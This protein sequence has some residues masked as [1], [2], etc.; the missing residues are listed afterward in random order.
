MSCFCL[1]VV[2]DLAPGILTIGQDNHRSLTDAET[3]ILSDLLAHVSLSIK[4][5]R[6]YTALQAAFADE[7]EPWVQPPLPAPD[8][9][10]SARVVARDFAQAHVCLASPGYPRSH[11]DLYPA[12]VLCTALGS[13]PSS[14]LFRTVREEQGLAYAVGSYPVVFSCAGALVAYAAAKPEAVGR[15]IETIRAQFR[16]LV[17]RGLADDELAETK[18]QL[19][20]RVELSLDDVGV[21]MERLGEGYIHERRVVPIAEIL[22]KLAAVTNEDIRRVAGEMFEGGRLALAVVGPVDPGG[23]AINS[24]PA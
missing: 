14:R 2:F 5:A 18:Q 3:H 10:G 12:R 6:L 15:I 16:D 1:P 9:S 21:R 8:F 11:P 13:G 19:L 20:A 4:N 24:W 7:R 17:D 23:L 22:G